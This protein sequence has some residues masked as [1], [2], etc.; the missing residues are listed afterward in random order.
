[1]AGISFDGMALWSAG[2]TVGLLIGYFFS[3][4][5]VLL[6]TIVVAVIFS[7]LRHYSTIRHGKRVNITLSEDLVRKLHET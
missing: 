2:Y 4:M 7:V 1:M 6:I 5:L 3:F